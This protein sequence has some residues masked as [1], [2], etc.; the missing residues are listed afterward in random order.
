MPK[1]CILVGPNSHV[2][3]SLSGPKFT[4]LFTSKAGGNFLVRTSFRFWICC[5]VLEIFAI[6]VLSGPKL[7]EILDVFVPQIFWREHIPNI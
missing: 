3:P 6:K 2:I 4:G 5:L 1:K 7:T